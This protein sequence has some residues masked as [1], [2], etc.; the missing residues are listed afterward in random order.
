M[1]HVGRLMAAFW[2]SA[3]C[4]LQ[5]TASAQ[6]PDAVARGKQ[7]FAD[8]KCAAC[9]AIAGVGNRR[10]ALDDVGAR[11]SGDDL[12]AWILDAPGMTSKSGSQ[13]RP[14]MRSYPN[15]PQADVDA[16]VAYMQSLTPESSKR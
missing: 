9:H 10:G 12:R 1:E 8:Q 6:T 14:Q 16:L 4:L 2:L 13:R 11:L 3:A 7:I 15:L 5:A